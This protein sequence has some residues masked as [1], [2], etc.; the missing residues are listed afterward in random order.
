MLVLSAQIIIPFRHITDL[1]EHSEI[2]ISLK[3]Y[4]IYLKCSTKKLD[5][6]SVAARKK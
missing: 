4:V 1:E 5:R 3:K 6:I 2:A